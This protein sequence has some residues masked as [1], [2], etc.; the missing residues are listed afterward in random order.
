MVIIT[1][2]YNATVNAGEGNDQTD[3]QEQQ[4]QHAQN[5]DSTNKA[6]T[7]EMTEVSLGSEYGSTATVTSTPPKSSSADYDAVAPPNFF[8]ATLMAFLPSLYFNLLTPGGRHGYVDVLVE[9]P[10]G[11]VVQFVPFILIIV[12]S[13][14][15]ETLSIWLAF[16]VS[17]LICLLDKYH[18]TY[19]PRFSSWYWLNVGPM[20]AYLAMGIVFAFKPFPAGLISSISVTVMW[21]SVLLS[22]LVGNPFTYQY[23]KSSAPDEALARPGFM[24]I[25]HLLAGYWLF[26]FTVMIIVSWVDY[27]MPWSKGSAGHIILG[28]VIPVCI[29]LFGATTMPILL[30][31]LR[32]KA[33]G[34]RLEKNGTDVDSIV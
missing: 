2:L 22:M 34:D 29:P 16:G 13:S 21:G 20:V 3:A 17:V 14:A 31:Y 28:I 30:E 33:A 5:A 10:L 6:A 11:R 25:C 27:A 8:Q 1:K 23:A 18:S 24:K 26:L 15:Y 4:Q 19:K 12:L 7:T 32:K 9:A